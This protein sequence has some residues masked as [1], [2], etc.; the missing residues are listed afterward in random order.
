MLTNI[1]VV[2]NVWVLLI[3]VLWTCL[4]FLLVHINKNYLKIQFWEC[5]CWVIASSMLLGNTSSTFFGLVK[6]DLGLPAV[7]I[8]N[9][10][11]SVTFEFYM[12]NKNIFSVKYGPCKI[13]IS[14]GNPTKVSELYQIT[15]I[16]Q[17]SVSVRGWGNIWPFLPHLGWPTQLFT[18]LAQGAQ[19][20]ANQLC[21]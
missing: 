10:G 6:K 3:V 14:S 2:S 20:L 11:F 16:G 4:F 7:A 18:R 9:T 19:V 8:E 13:Y 1:W 12:N 17:W 15:V 21:G 5:D